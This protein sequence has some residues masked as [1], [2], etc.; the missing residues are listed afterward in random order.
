MFDFS[1]G[2]LLLLAIVALVFIGPKELPAVLKAVA[3]A[4]AYLKSMS[5]E[6]KGAMDD[7]ARESGLKDAQAEIEREMRM[8]TGDDGKQYPAYDINDFL[9]PDNT[10]TP[11]A[12]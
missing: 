7:L 2:E 4:L 1:F 10:T 3:K 9:P 11:P 8:I 5:R 6:L 12:P